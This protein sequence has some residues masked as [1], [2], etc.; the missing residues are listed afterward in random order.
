MRRA[1]YLLIAAAFILVVVAPGC[2]TVLIHPADEGSTYY[3]RQTSDCVR[4]HGDY[5][6]YPYGY[7]Y[8][9]YPDY[10][11]NH[12]DYASYYAYPWWWSHYDYP[13]LDEDYEPGEI[14]ES[15]TKFGRREARPGPVPPPH[16]TR[17]R[18]R[19][20]SNYDPVRPGLYDLPSD[21]NTPSGGGTG[22]TRHNPG[23][24]SGSRSKDDNPP[25]ESNQPQK[26]T[27]TSRRIEDSGSSNT[28]DQGSTSR[29]KPA[30][31]KS[32]DTKT[33]KKS[34]RGGGGSR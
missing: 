31:D 22:A 23:G 27:R 20:D 13:Y 12:R 5:A 34:R 25:A 4:C 32:Q 15:R 10:W 19:W 2:Y 17:D 33:K 30:D 3:A 7:Y 16:S 18:D 11:W 28:S 14:S 1:L 21:L 8:S 26:P 24:V 9:P 29:D 6:E